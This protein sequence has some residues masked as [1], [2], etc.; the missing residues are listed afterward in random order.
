MDRPQIGVNPPSPGYG[1]TEQ[2]FH[3]PRCQ[4]ALVRIR[5]RPIDRFVSLILPRRRYRCMAIGCGWEGTFRAP[6]D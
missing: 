3:C 1:K 5:R 2:E 4:G 6:R